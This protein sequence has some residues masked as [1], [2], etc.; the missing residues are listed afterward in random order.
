[1]FKI[2]KI[3]FV[4]GEKE[5]GEKEEGEKERRKQGERF[6]MWA[7]NIS[8]EERNYLPEEAEVVFM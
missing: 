7:A 2:N 1:M 8:R 4:G 5:G 6:I 3:T